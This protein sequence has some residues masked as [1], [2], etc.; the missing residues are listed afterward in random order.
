MGLSLSDTHVGLGSSAAQWKT[1]WS[2]AHG[3]KVCATR[4]LCYGTAVKDNAVGSAFTFTY[5]T[6]DH[7]VATKFQMNLPNGTPVGN[8]LHDVLVT[9][10]ADAKFGNISIVKSG[11]SPSCA[12]AQGSSKTLKARLANAGIGQTGGA[13][14]IEMSGEKSHGSA[15]Y[16]KGS[17]VQTV[18][19]AIGPASRSRRC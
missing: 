15:Q 19:V 3:S 12:R 7:H 8:A 16:Y 6:F 17:D 18:L 9:L 4:V 13:F 2:V 11:S 5:V 1:A 14:N 10:P